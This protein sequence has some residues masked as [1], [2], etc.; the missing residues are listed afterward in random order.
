MESGKHIT[1]YNS[2]FFINPLVQL[3]SESKI[4]LFN[5]KENGLIGYH[6][7]AVPQLLIVLE[8]EGYVRSD[9]SEF[10]KL[11]FGE[12]VLW[13][14]G[15]WHETKSENGMLALVIESKILNDNQILLE[16]NV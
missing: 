5:L 8:G 12:A 14:A 9:E 16:K 7:A 3:D 13:T 4:A 6:Q 1:H 2:N 15:E 11:S 10:I